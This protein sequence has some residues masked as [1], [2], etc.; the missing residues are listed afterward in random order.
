MTQTN[1]TPALLANSTLPTYDSAYPAGD[2]PAGGGTWLAQFN[3]NSGD[4]STTV[5]SGVS[6]QS[7]Q[8]LGTPAGQSEQGLQFTYDATIPTDDPSNSE[9]R[10]T[11]PPAAETWQ[12]IRLFIPA[13]FFHRQIT[14]VEVSG[15]IS[16]WVSGDSIIG[17]DGSTATI[18]SKATNV[19]FLLFAE[20]SYSNSSWVG[21]ITNT[22]RSQTRTS[23]S[24]YVEADNNKLFTKWAD[25]YSSSGAGPT[26]VWEFRAS[27]DGGSILG[28][29]YSAGAYTNTGAHGRDQIFANDLITP[30]D[31]GAW[32]E[33]IFHVKMSS[34][35]GVRDGVIGVYQKKSGASVFTKILEQTEADIGAP[36]EAVTPTQLSQGY[37]SGYSNSGYDVQTSLYVSQF[38]HSN[39]LPE[40]LA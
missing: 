36:V 39:T 10:F 33:L 1:Q 34:A 2:R 28:Q 27:G 20:N 23:T 16:S 40:E 3:F 14:V 26:I 21:S 8:A 38:W 30:A 35:R 7:V 4:T 11:H 25:D 18:H 37:F 22:T 31:F 29:Q 24:R 5:K 15:D 19:V 17:V 12:K 13:N 9:I 6:F 32:M